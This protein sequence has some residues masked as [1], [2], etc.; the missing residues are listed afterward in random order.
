IDEES[1]LPLGRPWL[2]IC[3]DDFTRCILGLFISFE[4]PSYLSVAR[5]L[6]NAFLPKTSL[7]EKYP[8]VKNRWDAHGIMREL[9][10]DNGREF[11]SKSLEAACYSVGTEIHYAPRKVAW[12][13][14]KVERVQGTLN[15]GV[16]HG[17]PGTTFSN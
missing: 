4:P 9:V 1:G 2:T 3:I 12:F 7:Q 17:T 6:K 14:G 13:K 16:A 11:H 10:V 15:R 5:C 8:S